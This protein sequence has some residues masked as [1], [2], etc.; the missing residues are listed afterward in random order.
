MRKEISKTSLDFLNKEK[1][2][3]FQFP[4]LN[5]YE[6]IGKDYINNLYKSEYFYLYKSFF[7]EDKPQSYKQTDSNVLR[8]YWSVFVT[9]EWIIKNNLD[10]KN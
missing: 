2:H 6:N 4:L 5:W 9:N 7:N 1:K 8:L 3:G 10:I